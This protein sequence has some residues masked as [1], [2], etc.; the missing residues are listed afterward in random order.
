MGIRPFLDLRNYKGV[1]APFDL[2]PV[3]RGTLLRTGRLQPEEA[4]HQTEAGV[5]Y[6]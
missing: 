3:Y 6:M 1:T 4:A 2:F 5:R